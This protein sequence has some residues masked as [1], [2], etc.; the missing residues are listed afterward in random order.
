MSAYIFAL[1]HLV[2]NRNKWTT[3]NS[4]LRHPF[5]LPLVL[6]L[7]SRLGSALPQLSRYLEH[8]GALVELLIRFSERP[9][10]A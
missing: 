7:P 9:S 4:P 2:L 8:A 3:L 1:V 6:W 10:A 5:D